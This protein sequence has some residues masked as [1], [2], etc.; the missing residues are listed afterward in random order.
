M[1]QTSTVAVLSLILLVAGCGS[2]GIDRSA[3]EPLVLL[4][5]ATSD[6]GVV[7]SACPDRRS[8][9]PSPD[10]SKEARAA[11]ARGGDALDRLT[12][13]Y[14]A[15]HGIWVDQTG[16]VW[17]NL[18]E[19]DTPPAEEL[20]ESVGSPVR[21]AMRTDTQA[22]L[23]ERATETMEVVAAIVEP[24]DPVVSVRW[25]SQQY[26]A[27]VVVNPRRSNEDLG[28]IWESLADLDLVEGVGLEV[29]VDEES[30]G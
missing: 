10:P 26:C 11:I 4:E 13:E 3:E 28:P 20:V 18:T 16:T 17:L 5:P 23:V 22:E 14:E 1:R 9:V 2:V 25:L 29:S 7:P 6:D 8:V 19:Q 12:A 15:P 24:Y 30:E 21:F 27:E